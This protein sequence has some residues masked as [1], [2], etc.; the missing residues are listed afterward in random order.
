MAVLATISLTMIHV[1]RT[2]HNAST[3]TGEVTEELCEP[4]GE[5]T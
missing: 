3:D 4:I 1:C 5:S 2:S